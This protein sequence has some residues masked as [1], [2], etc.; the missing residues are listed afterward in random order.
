MNILTA[1]IW[2]NLFLNI[3]GMFLCTRNTSS[4]MESILEYLN[5]IEKLLHNIFFSAL[6]SWWLLIELFSISKSLFSITIYDNS[7]IL[8]LFIYKL[9]ILII[10]T[11][12][13]IIRRQ[14]HIFDTKCFLFVCIQ[15]F[16]SCGYFDDKNTIRPSYIYFTT[17]FP[18]NINWNA[19]G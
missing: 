17:I 12:L 5:N 7:W 4:I 13:L 14:K 1:S 2:L 18:W 16:S 19:Y 6:A 8:F 10:D 9:S 11:M 3:V 15:Y